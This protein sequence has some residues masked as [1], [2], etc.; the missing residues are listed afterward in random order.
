MAEWYFGGHLIRDRISRD[1]ISLLVMAE[2]YFG[3]HF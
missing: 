3:G 2:W 1:R